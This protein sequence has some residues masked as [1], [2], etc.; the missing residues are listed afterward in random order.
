L[1]SRQAEDTSREWPDGVEPF[2]ADVTDPSQLAGAASGCDCVLHLAGIA[3]ERP[4][5]VTFETVHVQGTR[6]VVREAESAEVTRVVFVSSLGAANGG[7]PYH[8]SK[9][10]AED[11]VRGFSGE[12]VIVRSGNVYGPG[13]ELVSTLLNMVRSQLAVP[14]IDA[15]DQRFQPIWFADLGQVLARAVESEELVA[16]TLEVAGTE[17]TTPRELIDRL[18]KITGQSPILLPIPSPIAST[19]TAIADA[20]GVPLPINPA[21]LTMQLE[22]RLLDPAENALTRTFRVEPTPLFAGLGVLADASPEQTP[23]DGVGVLERKRFWANI[24]G[25][26]CSPSELLELF[27]QRCGDILPIAIDAEPG[28]PRILEQGRT[29]TMG[30]PLRGNMQVRV[31]EV[32]AWR[33]TLATLRGHPLAGVI[34]FTTD[35]DADRVRFEVS[36]LARAANLGDWLTMHTIGE[37]MQHFSWHLAMQ[38]VVELSG[39]TAPQGIESDSK[40]LDDAAARSIDEWIRSR[41]AERNR[42]V[43]AA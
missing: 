5:E 17:I 9:L 25:S 6:N 19:G 21:K 23:G 10:A 36:I 8:C 33:I 18:S 14:V 16:R 35:G 37:P 42:A 11:I 7:S 1:L 3:T 39:G 4:P 32:T 29:L 28:S 20:L 13:D 2:P 26:R 34:R 31:E 15:G 24:V 22:E 41:I 30:V 12:W 27:R 38:R 40:V 43:E